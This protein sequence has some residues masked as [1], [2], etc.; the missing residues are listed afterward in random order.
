[1][2]GDE[3]KKLQ[4]FIMRFNGALDPNYLAFPFAS[5]QVGIWNWQRWVSPAFD[6]ALGKAAE[7]MDRAKRASY[8][9]DAQKAME[10]SAAFVW[11]THETLIYVRRNSVKPSLGP[12]GTSVNFNRFEPV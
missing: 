11:L 9:V 7:E 6:E 2:K 12:A 8:I 1:G 5:D 3:G 4:M 10:E